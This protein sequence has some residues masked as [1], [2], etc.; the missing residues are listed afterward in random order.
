MFTPFVDEH[1]LL[2]V[3]GRLNK[4]NLFY[5]QRHPLLLPHDHH[6]TNMIL[7]DF[8]NDNMHSGIQ[9]TLHLI[10]SRY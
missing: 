6:I 9:S 7:H 4:A 5:G 2:R 3:D 1:G 10:R 8:H